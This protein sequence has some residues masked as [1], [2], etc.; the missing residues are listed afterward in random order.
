MSRAGVALAKRAPRSLTGLTQPT[1]VSTVSI[2]AMGI[3]LE[4][5]ADLG[6]LPTAPIFLVALDRG[7]TGELSGKVFV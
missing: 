7:C 2:L 3:W 1:T 5:G 6:N 4:K